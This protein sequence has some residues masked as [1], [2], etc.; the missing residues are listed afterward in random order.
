MQKQN[1]KWSVKYFI[2]RTR[3][4][5]TLLFR[6]VL[7][8][9]KLHQFF[10][11]VARN[12]FYTQGWKFTPYGNIVRQHQCRKQARAGW[13]DCARCIL[14]NVYEIALKRRLL[15]TEILPRFNSKFCVRYWNCLLSSSLSHLWWCARDAEEKRVWLI[16]GR[17]DWWCRTRGC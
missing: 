4:S 16:K 11:G 5:K 6:M 9:L 7:K 10:D 2:L 12:F 14:P 15:K 13:P 3:F 1:W 8:R 17:K